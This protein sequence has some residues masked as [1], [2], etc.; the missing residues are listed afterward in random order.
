MVSVR[1]DQPP[2]E[3]VRGGIQLPHSSPRN[4]RN[5][6]IKLLSHVN[7]EADQGFGFEGKILRPGSVVT[8]AELRP[9][10]EYPERPVLLE[11]AQAPA[12]G[13]R[14][15][16]RTESLYV[17]WSLDA[18]SNTWREL[19]RANAVSWEWAVDLRPLALRAMQQRPQV[20][21]DLLAVEMRIM[22]VLER[23]LASVAA[24]QQSLVLAIIHDQI[25][26]AVVN[27]ASSPKLLSCQ[28]G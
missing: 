9:T 28:A 10:D 11:Y 4:C 23:E 22:A 16:N 21:P 19:G 18:Q 14:G 2:P 12:Q 17:L 27:G 25:A 6:F 24:A 1:T 8:E 15:H 5:A 20:M 26:V 7:P 13:K 3:I